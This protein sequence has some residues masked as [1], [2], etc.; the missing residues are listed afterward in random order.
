MSLKCSALYLAQFRFTSPHLLASGNGTKSAYIVGDVYIHPS[1]K[2]HPTAK[3]IFSPFLYICT[4]HL[5]KLVNH[6]CTMNFKRSF[7]PYDFLHQ[8]N[9]FRK[10]LHV[11]HCGHLE[12]YTL[13]NRLREAES[14]PVFLTLVRFILS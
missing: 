1:A 13:V 10:S 6:A 9:A 12:I 2:V 14:N 8:P 3:V 5:N 4:F 7:M 11:I